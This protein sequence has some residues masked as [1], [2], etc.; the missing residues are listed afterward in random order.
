MENVGLILGIYTVRIL[1]VFAFFWILF[2]DFFEY[3]KKTNKGK[4]VK[5]TNH[6]ILNSGSS[7]LLSIL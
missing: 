1:A 2:E 3:K 5:P 6:A 7:C 4:A